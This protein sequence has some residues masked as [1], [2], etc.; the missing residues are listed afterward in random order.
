MYSQKASAWVLCLSTQQTLIFAGNLS[1]L[2]RHKFPQ[3]LPASIIFCPSCKSACSNIH[4]DQPSGSLLYFFSNHTPSSAL[5]SMIIRLIELY[6]ESILKSSCLHSS[7]ALWRPSQYL[8]NR[9]WYKSV[10]SLPNYLRY[11]YSVQ[12]A[13]C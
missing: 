8:P 1:R 7:A 3:P 9:Q 10:S 13:F 4:L 12:K 2:Q 5:R 11:H 6:K